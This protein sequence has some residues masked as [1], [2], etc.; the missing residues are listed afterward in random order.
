M[1]ALGARR[2]HLRAAIA[3]ETSILGIAGLIGGVVLGGELS[4]MLVK[5]LT[6]V[7]DPPPAAITVPWVYLGGLAALIVGCLVAVTVGTLRLAGRSLLPT[8]RRL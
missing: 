3:G 4:T 5:V 1:S 2:R 7:F 6:G 8:I